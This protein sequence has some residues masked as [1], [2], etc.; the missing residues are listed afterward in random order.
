MIDSELTFH[1]HITRL[2]SKTDQKFSALD[3]V[4]KYMILPK[5]RLFMSCYVTSQFSYCH[6]VW[7]IHNRKLNKKIKF[8]ET[9]FQDR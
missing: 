8:L 6:L 5:Q 4:S 9:S 7:I 2:S 3:R 1:G